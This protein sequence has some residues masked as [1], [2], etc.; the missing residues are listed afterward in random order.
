MP[1]ECS[2]D[3]VIGNL[4]LVRLMTG[5]QYARD[6]DCQHDGYQMSMIHRYIMDTDKRWK[7]LVNKHS[8]LTLKSRPFF[9][10]GDRMCC[11]AKN[12]RSMNI[13][14][15]KRVVYILSVY[16]VSP[17]VFSIAILPKLHTQNFK[18]A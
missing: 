9:E 18:T 3:R 7:S 13:F 17:P 4:T 14:C 12:Y 10:C 2:N 15:L 1:V 5:S 6:T 11:N 16:H 8:I